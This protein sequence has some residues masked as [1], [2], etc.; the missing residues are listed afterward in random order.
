MLLLFFGLTL[1]DM[2]RRRRQLAEMLDR[3][4]PLVERTRR[5]HI[6]NMR[7]L[8]SSLFYTGNLL[9]QLEHEVTL[10]EREKGLPSPTGTARF[11]LRPGRGF[12]DLEKRL[13]LLELTLGA[14]GAPVGH[15]AGPA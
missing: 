11:S 13:A 10:R 6:R 7:G 8:N 1:N 14:T 5:L 9:D 15:E 12:R 4:E 2:D 3:V